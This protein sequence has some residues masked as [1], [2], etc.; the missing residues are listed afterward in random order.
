[1][2]KKKCIFYLLINLFTSLD[3]I[4]IS[5]WNENIWQDKQLQ[6]ETAFWGVEKGFKKVESVL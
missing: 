1:M 3:F 5:Y 2:L 4:S 6:L